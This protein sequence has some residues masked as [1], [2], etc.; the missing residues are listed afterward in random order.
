M[1]SEPWLQVHAASGEV[2]STVSG[3]Q[4]PVVDLYLPLLCLLR[5]NNT[6][7]GVYE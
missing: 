3:A 6:C 2:V 7:P 1:T 4:K 5:T